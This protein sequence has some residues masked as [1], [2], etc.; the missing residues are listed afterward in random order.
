M[1]VETSTYS[2]RLNYQGSLVSDGTRF[3]LSS[4]NNHHVWVIQPGPEGGWAVKP[5]AGT[6][7]AGFSGDEGP[8]RDAQLRFPAGLA[9]DAQGN[10]DF[11]D[12]GNHRV[13]KIDINA[14][15]V[16]TVWPTGEPDNASTPT[17]LAF[18]A[19]GNL[20]IA[21]AG[22]HRVSRVDLAAGTAQVIAGTG[23][24]GFSGD[25]GPAAE[26]ML[27]R[28]CGIAFDSNGILYIADTGNQRIRRLRSE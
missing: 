12:S 14:G 22:L 8:S 4:P 11:A 15:T 25:G 10:L 18:D 24:P 28:P 26:A 27:S 19:A 13:R 23:T 3:F 6:G 5:F 1:P 20:Y 16:T 7:E 21:D 2:T 9:L 17:G